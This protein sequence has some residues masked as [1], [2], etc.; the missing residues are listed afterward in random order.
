[1]SLLAFPE[2]TLPKPCAQHEPEDI[3]RSLAYA[4]RFCALRLDCAGVRF[5]F[6]SLLPRLPSCGSSLSASSA[7][8]LSTE[9]LGSIE[10]CCPGGE[11]ELESAAMLASL[12]SE[13]S[14]V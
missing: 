7:M 12:L 6:S 9:P 5:S 8:P 1:M 4:A 14:N 3:V 10:N 11:A 2:S 13:A